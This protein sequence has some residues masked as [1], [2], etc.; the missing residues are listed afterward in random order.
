MIDANFSKIE[1]FFPE[2]SGKNA[3]SKQI[4]KGDRS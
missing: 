4:E 1:C 2:G 3:G